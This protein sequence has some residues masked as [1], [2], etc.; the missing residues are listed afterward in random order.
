MT[1]K[2]TEKVDGNITITT[3]D[4]QWNLKKDDPFPSDLPVNLANRLRAIKFDVEE[5]KGESDES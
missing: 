4:K 3:H 5:E 1:A 2:K